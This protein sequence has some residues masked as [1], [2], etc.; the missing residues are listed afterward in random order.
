MNLYLETVTFNT[1]GSNTIHSNTFRPYLVICF[2]WQ[3]ISIDKYLP[4]HRQVDSKQI[5]QTQHKKLMYNLHGMVF[6]RPQWT[7]RIINYVPLTLR[8]KREFFIIWSSIC[9]IC[10]WVSK[11]VQYTV[12]VQLN[13]LLGFLIHRRHFNG[14]VSWT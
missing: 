6:H 13:V 8:L 11:Y 2:A 4:L 14:L 1:I 7:W 10:F 9:I 12:R 5:P 3:K